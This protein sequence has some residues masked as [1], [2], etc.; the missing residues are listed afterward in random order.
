MLN[1]IECLFLPRWMANIEYI[2]QNAA[3]A[4]AA[5]ALWTWSTHTDTHTHI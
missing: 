5:A 1:N 3:V 2:E 4:A